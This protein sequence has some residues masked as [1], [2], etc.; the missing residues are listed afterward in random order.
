MVQKSDIEEQADETNQKGNKSV[1]QLNHKLYIFQEKKY[2]QEIWLEGNKIQQYVRFAD[3]N[4]ENL[5]E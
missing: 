4:L 5:Q 2:T 3:A 1:S